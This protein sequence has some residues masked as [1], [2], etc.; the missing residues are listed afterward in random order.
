[1]GATDTRRG[2]AERDK[3]M[4]TARRQKSNRNFTAS[5]SADL[6]AYKRQINLANV[7]CQNRA[8]TAEFRIA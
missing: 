8:R 6:P 1:M 3:D 4:G 5:A 2:L 7:S